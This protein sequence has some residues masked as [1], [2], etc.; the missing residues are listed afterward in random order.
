MSVEYIDI[1]IDFGEYLD[2][3]MDIRIPQ[4]ITTKELLQTLVEA[5]SLQLEID[6]PIVR[7]RGTNVLL[8]SFSRIA[9][10]SDIRSGSFLIVEKI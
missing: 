9:D 5:Y 3:V 7:M 6:N 1:S 4:K 2:R 8:T 10:F